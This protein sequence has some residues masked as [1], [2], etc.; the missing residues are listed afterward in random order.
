MPPF[1]RLSVS[2]VFAVLLVLGGAGV[3]YSCFDYDCGL[4]SLR[5]LERS[6]EEG[7]RLER[8][9]QAASERNTGKLEVVE[10]VL[11]RRLTLLQ[12]A[13]EFRQIH[14]RTRTDYDPL[15]K[16]WSEDLSDEAMCSL[17]LAWI[18]GTPTVE[19]AQLAAVLADL[20]KEFV[21]HFHHAP[22]SRLGP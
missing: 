3:T 18:E 7:E 6:R 20:R 9:V 21:A 16:G 8:R 22:A 17:V 13:S 4:A 1:L 2:A 11:A 14:E 12:A 19:A 5:Q 15:C 10:R